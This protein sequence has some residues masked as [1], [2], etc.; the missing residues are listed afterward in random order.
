M[1]NYYIQ[2]T[3]QLITSGRDVEVLLRQLQRTLQRKG[4]LKLY[5]AIL[6]GVLR[7]LETKK[8]SL[9]PIV[10]LANESD[11][12]KY[13]EQIRR[14]LTALGANGDFSI[15]TDPSI[16]GGLIASYDNKVLDQSYKKALVGLYRSI[17]S[18]SSPRAGK[19]V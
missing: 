11:K 9:L 16:T 13:A 8:D 2:A 6:R 17:I 14:A 15:N 10:T 7:A 18:T 5:P 19:K 12:E 3:L 4:H 1:K